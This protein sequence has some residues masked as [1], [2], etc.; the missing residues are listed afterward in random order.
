[1]SFVAHAGSF[2]LTAIERVQLLH[3]R[4]HVEQS[5]N[6]QLL[7]LMYPNAIL[8]ID[9]A[10]ADNSG[11]G[12]TYEIELTHGLTIS[13][14]T[15]RVNLANT[16][17]RAISNAASLAET[18]ECSVELGLCSNGF[19]Q[20]TGANSAAHLTDLL[21]AFQRHLLRAYLQGPLVGEHVVFKR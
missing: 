11:Q 2:D 9:C 17:C 13:T 8:V 1:M 19:G 12:P 18:L 16:T 6:Q 3:Y 4:S 15:T 14:H 10:S 21:R 7:F 5:S 20:D